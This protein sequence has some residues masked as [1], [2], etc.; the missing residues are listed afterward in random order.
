MW[1]SLVILAASIKFSLKMT[2]SRFFAVSLPKLMEVKWLGSA[3]IVISAIS[4][5]N[6]LF[7]VYGSQIFA[8][9]P[10]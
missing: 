9:K 7:M 10:V 1:G 6:V 3:M 5:T 8:L 4:A 2:L